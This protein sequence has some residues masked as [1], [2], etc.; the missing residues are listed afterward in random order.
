MEVVY[1]RDHPPSAYI[2]GF[3]DRWGPAFED[4]IFVLVLLGLSLSIGYNSI[5]GT[6]DRLKSLTGYWDTLRGGS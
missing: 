4:L 1:N 5:F 2:D 6:G 3:L